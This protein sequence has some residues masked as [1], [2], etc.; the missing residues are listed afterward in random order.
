MPMIALGALLLILF[1]VISVSDDLWSVQNPAEADTCLRRNDTP[2]GAHAILP[3]LASLPLSTFVQ[4]ATEA[5]TYFPP[6]RTPLL[7]RVTPAF[8]PAENRPPPTA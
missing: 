6:V 5:W 3:P 8:P 4:T 2:S 1:P 7:R